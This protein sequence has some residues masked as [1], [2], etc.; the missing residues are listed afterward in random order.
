MLVFTAVTGV[1]VFWN[2]MA[3]QW[4]QL[5]CAHMLVL[6]WDRSTRDPP[7]NPQELWSFQ[8]GSDCEFVSDLHA[9]VG[10]PRFKGQGLRSC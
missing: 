1:S 8:W 5:S 6:W 7:H 3:S 4:G 9:V 2:G 10:K